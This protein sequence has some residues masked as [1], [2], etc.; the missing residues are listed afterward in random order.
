VSFYRN[1]HFLGVAF[2][3][4]RTMP[5]MIAYFPAGSLSHCERCQL[6]FGARP[7]EHPVEGFLPIELPPKA[8]Q[9]RCGKEL[10]AGWGRLAQVVAQ[11]A[12]QD[13]ARASGP[14]TEANSS[15]S[16]TT[17]AGEPGAGEGETLQGCA[18]AAAEAAGSVAL[19]APTPESLT[20]QASLAGLSAGP[21]LHGPGVSSRAVRAAAKP[22]GYCYLPWEEGIMLASLLAQ[23]LVPY[24]VSWQ[25]LSFVKGR[26]CPTSRMQL[27]QG[28]AHKVHSYSLMSHLHI[29]S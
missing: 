18:S 10:M 13:A 2:S 26:V 24:L 6:N 22:P 16:T 14:T 1:G 12:A 27:A 21:S 20:V 25:G 7:F 15:A 28:V 3:N 23:Y 19:T 9:M 8:A 5:T 11:S 4:V 17:T 29:F